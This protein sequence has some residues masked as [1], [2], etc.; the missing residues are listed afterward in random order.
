MFALPI[1]NQRIPQQVTNAGCRTDAQL[2]AVKSLLPEVLFACNNPFAQEYPGQ[3]FNRTF[4]FVYYN[5]ENK[6]AVRRI[7]PTG[8]I[9]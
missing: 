4:S 1:S 3:R 6:L 7:T 9:K 5:R 8:R 2:A